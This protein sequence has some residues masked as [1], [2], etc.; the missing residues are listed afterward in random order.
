V[1]GIPPLPQA[2]T[3]AHQLELVVFHGGKGVSSMIL[4]NR[5][6]GRSPALRSAPSHMEEIDLHQA[7]ILVLD[8]ARISQA[9]FARKPHPLATRLFDLTIASLVLV[10][11]LPVLA[12]AA[13]LVATTS[14][15]P[16]IYRQQ[17]FGQHGRTFVLYKFRT[18]VRNADA[19]LEHSPVLRSAFARQWKLDRD[20]RITRIGHWLRISSIDEL[21]QLVN[22]LRGQMSIVGP[23]PVQPGEITD[24]YKEL[25]LVVFS[26][27]PGLT[28]L[29]QVKGRSCTS[30]EERIAMDIE[31]LRRRSFWFDLQL[32]VR[33]IPAVLLR[34]GAR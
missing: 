7:H 16:V 27:K 6:P 17:R 31:Y 2:G 33:T 29:W 5:Q 19:I 28:G 12:L 26:V 13:L 22:V 14:R 15:G 34:R 10:M 21:P 18:M 20:P 3:L 30:Y 24:W 32:L 9:A 1:A 11:A 23:R 25:G 8:A 4:A